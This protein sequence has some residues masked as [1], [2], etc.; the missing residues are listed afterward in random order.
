MT[1]HPPSSLEALIT[2]SKIRQS[3]FC[4]SQISSF[5]DHQYLLVRCGLQMDPDVKMISLFNKEKRFKISETTGSEITYRWMNCRSCPTCKSSERQKD[6]SIKGEA[7]QELIINNSSL[8]LTP[9]LSLQRYLCFK[10]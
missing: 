7:E 8:I 2:F 3:L 6:I 1:P 10:I 5:F 4:Q 9:I